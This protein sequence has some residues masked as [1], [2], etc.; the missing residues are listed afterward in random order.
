[1]YIYAYVCVVKGFKLYQQIQKGHFYY[2][3]TKI[4][5]KPK[6]KT[7]ENLNELKQKKSSQNITY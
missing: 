7:T 5:R 1:M 2:P 6:G 4:I 3:T